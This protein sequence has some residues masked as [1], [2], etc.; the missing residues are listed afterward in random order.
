MRAGSMYPY[1]D[2]QRPSAIFNSWASLTLIVRYECGLMNSIFATVPMMLI[3]L[4]VFKLIADVNN[5]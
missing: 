3:D 4:R 1:W 2:V 5:P